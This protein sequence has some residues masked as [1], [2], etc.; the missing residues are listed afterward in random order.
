MQ[1]YFLLRYTTET[2]TFLQVPAG[3]VAAYALPVNTV[4]K[5]DIAEIT[6]RIFFTNQIVLNPEYFFRN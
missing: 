1:V 4:K 2:P 6:R 3:Y 5:I